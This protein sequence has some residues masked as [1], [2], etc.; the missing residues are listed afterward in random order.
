[1]EN[2]Q[3][4]QE[5]EIRIELDRVK[6]I[7]SIIEKI[8]AKSYLEI[9]V[10]NGHTFKQISPKIRVKVGVDPNEKS[11]ATIKK[12]SD[13]YF[14][15]LSSDTFFD[16]IFIDG[17]HEAVQVSKDITNALNHLSTNGIIVVHDLNPV[18]EIYQR[19][20]R[21]SNIWNG[22]VWRSWVE[23]KVMRPTVNAICWNCDEGTGTIQKAKLDNTVYTNSKWNCS[24]ATYEYFDKNRVRMLNLR[25]TSQFEYWLSKLPKIYK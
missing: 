25:P 15:T 5:K 17:L 16:V 13:D 2:E 11:V 14:S 18:S 7:N 12:T 21:V 8:G 6:I 1:M 4:V 24:N 19:V 10:E 3:E 20:P 23:L 22:D 9:G